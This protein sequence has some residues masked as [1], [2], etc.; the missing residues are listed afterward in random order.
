MLTYRL[1]GHLGMDTCILALVYVLL[2]YDT[3]KMG[4]QAC[5][6]EHTAFA[7]A[8]ALAFAFTATISTAF[9]FACFSVPLP[10]AARKVLIAAMVS[11][12]P[13]AISW[14]WALIWPS[15]AVC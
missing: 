13:D 7:T 6:C 10:W 9:S 11:F 5:K 12:L 4:E 2:H 3:S 15:K 1:R 14:I 8:F